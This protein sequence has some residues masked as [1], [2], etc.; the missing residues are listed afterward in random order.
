MILVVLGYQQHWPFWSTAFQY[1]NKQ[2]N[3]P[4][5][6]NNSNKNAGVVYDT[7]FLWTCQEMRQCPFFI[8]LLFSLCHHEYFGS[9]NQ[10]IKDGNYAVVGGKYIC[11]MFQSYIYL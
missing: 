6:T 7:R 8:N 4:N 3:K 11:Q 10:R 2:E 1:G 5:Q 9:R